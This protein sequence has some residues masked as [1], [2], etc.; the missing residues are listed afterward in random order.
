MRELGC[1]ADHKV[2][3]TTNI[4]AF[5]NAKMTTRRRRGWVDDRSVR[6][7]ATD[8]FSS[9]ERSDEV[10]IGEELRRMEMRDEDEDEDGG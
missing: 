6:D 3:M 5:I 8:L 9:M 2:E 4:Q 1:F 10:E 7:W